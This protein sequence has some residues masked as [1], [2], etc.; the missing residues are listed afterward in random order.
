MS[1]FFVLVV[2]AIILYCIMQNNDTEHNRRKYVTIITFILIVVAGLRHVA[3]GNDTLA[4]WDKFEAI[5]YNSWGELFNSFWVGLFNPTQSDLGK[6]PGM[7]ILNK[8]L[9]YVIYNQ[10]IY[11]LLMASIMLVPLGIFFYRNSTTL[12]QLLF[13]YSFYITLYFSYLPCSAIRQSIAIGL[14]IMGYIGLTENKV[15]KFIFYLALAVLFHKSSVIGVLFLIIFLLRKPF[16]AYRWTLVAFFCVLMFYNYLGILLA[17]SNEI[18]AMYSGSYY[19]TGASKPF[20]VIVL[21]VGFYL[22][23]LFSIKRYKND[24]LD[25]TTEFAMIGT[26]LTTTFIPLIRLDPSLVR[27]TGYFVM[28]SCLFVPQ[29]IMK[30]SSSLRK[31]IFIM[32][33]LLFLYR[34]FSASEHYAFFWQ[35]MIL[36]ERYR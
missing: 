13:A 11:L 19:E 7:W 8:A 34:S 14:L 23:G 22:I 15:K 33:I 36:H 1:V 29:S 18:Y 30:Y 25:Q 4:Y 28:W 24:G 5:R 26:S 32:C 10:Q 16:W 21:Y 35:D 20:V 2:F 27:I 17:D 9:S 6:D 31:L 3:V 12:K